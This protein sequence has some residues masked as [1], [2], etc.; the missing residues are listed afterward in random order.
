VKTPAKIVTRAVFWPLGWF[1][2]FCLSCLVWLLIGLVIIGVVLVLFVKGYFSLPPGLVSAIT[3]GPSPITI[4]ATTI[5]DKIQSLSQLTVTRFSYSSVITAQRDLPPL[6]AGIYGDKLVMVAVGHV[7]AGIDMR[8]LSSSS[9]TGDA[10]AMT[11]R[12]P[13]P[14]LLECFLNEQAS[15]IVSRDTGLFARPAPN[16]DL[17]SRRYAVH[18]FRDMALKDDILNEVQKNAQAAIR[19]FV[20]N[21]GVKS[22]TVVTTQPDP[23]AP[24]PDSCQ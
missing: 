4:Q 19:A 5:L 15:T 2:P 10:D 11:I 3:G 22:V 23:N 21:L 17:E 14:Q 12:L 13:P 20:A 7:N 6:L 16:L 9:V 24:L 8:Q 1:R 18:Q